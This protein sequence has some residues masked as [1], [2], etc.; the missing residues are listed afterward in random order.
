[1]ASI[2]KAKQGWNA[3]YYN[4]QAKAEY[5]PSPFQVSPKNH[6]KK[7]FATAIPIT[8][9][10]RA[11]LTESQIKLYELRKAVKPKQDDSAPDR[12]PIT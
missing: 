4:A 2:E 8:K 5:N 3:C 6:L 9:A 12:C 11:K 1:M 10:T 7:T